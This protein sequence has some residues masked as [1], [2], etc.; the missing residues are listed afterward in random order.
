[1]SAFYFLSLQENVVSPRNVFTGHR[2]NTFKL[3]SLVSSFLS[4]QLLL[5]YFAQLPGG[6]G[7]GSSG[8]Q[9]IL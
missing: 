7:L 8:E 4:I 9:D 1:M 3:N 6:R 5:L 2:G